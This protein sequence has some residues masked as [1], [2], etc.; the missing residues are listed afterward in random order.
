[1]DKKST[2]IEI[3]PYYMPYELGVARQ[4]FSRQVKE[5]QELISKV[6]MLTG[7]LKADID[8]YFG[9]ELQEYTDILPEQVD[10]FIAH[11]QIFFP[12]QCVGFCPSKAFLDR[13]LIRNRIDPAPIRNLIE[14]GVLHL[15]RC[16]FA[17]DPAY[18]NIRVDLTFLKK[19]RS[20]LRGL[21]SHDASP[22]PVGHRYKENHTFP[23][24][25]GPRDKGASPT[26]AEIEQVLGEGRTDAE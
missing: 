16:S 5:I 6:E 1:M 2:D 8:T 21:C 26:L 4:H 17:S 9:E 12:F 24:S 14:Q 25:I 15:D 3:P 7:R 19:R 10:S 20:Q 18:I 23:G 11:D 22:G 13:I